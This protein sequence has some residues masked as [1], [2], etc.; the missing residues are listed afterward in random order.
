MQSWPARG[1]AIDAT[2]VKVRM[3][4]QGG[5]DWSQ[6]RGSATFMAIDARCDA[7][8]GR[9][10]WFAHLGR[11]SIQPER[12]ASGQAA[13]LSISSHDMT[14]RVGRHF[15]RTRAR[16]PAGLRWTYSPVR[17]R[18]LGKIRSPENEPNGGTPAR[19][20]ICPDAARPGG[21]PADRFR[22]RAWRAAARLALPQVERRARSLASNGRRR[23]ATLSV[24]HGRSVAGGFRSRGSAGAP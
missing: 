11:P 6:S 5:H 19:L 20:A 2:P 4:A 13:N 24:Y 1:P 15:R 18:L 10:A 3:A 17:A 12:R 14:V 23:R 9:T 8:E 7:D 16:V 22:Q 21:Q